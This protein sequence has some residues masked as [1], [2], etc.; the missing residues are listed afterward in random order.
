[1]MLRRFFQDYKT[2]ENKAVEVDDFQ[3]PEASLGIVEGGIGEVSLA[4][5]PSIAVRKRGIPKLAALRRLP[6]SGRVVANHQNDHVLHGDHPL[7]HH[8]FQV[9]KQ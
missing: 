6:R 7:L 8:G 5:A 1:M 9:R 3:G 2:L 4:K